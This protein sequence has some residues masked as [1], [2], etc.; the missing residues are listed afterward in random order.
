MAFDAGVA[1]SSGRIQPNMRQDARHASVF[2]T[3]HFD[4]RSI[5]R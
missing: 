4:I 5:L 2:D 1:V 3:M